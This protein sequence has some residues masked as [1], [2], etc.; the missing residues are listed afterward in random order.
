MKLYTDSLKGHIEEVTMEKLELLETSKESIRQLK[1]VNEELFARL[2]QEK[3]V[4]KT[5]VKEKIQSF[6]EK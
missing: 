5:K 3:T 6:E 2:E 1:R 4:V